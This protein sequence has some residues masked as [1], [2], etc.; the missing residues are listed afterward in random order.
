MFNQ[1]K[2]LN[3]F[4]ALPQ[5]QDY[6]SKTDSEVV[7]LLFDAYEDIHSI[8]PNVKISDRMIVKQMLFKA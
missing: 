3:Y 7:S 6:K 5:Y 2:V 8:Y 4:K 1:D